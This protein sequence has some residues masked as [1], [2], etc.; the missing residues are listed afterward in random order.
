[1]QKSY[2]VY[3][4][5]RDAPRWGNVVHTRLDNFTTSIMLMEAAYPAEGKI[6]NS[7]LLN[8]SWPIRNGSAAGTLVEVSQNNFQAENAAWIYPRYWHGYLVFLKPLLTFFNLQILR[9]INFLLQ[10]F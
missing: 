10:F 9:E 8:P 4:V 3:K 2:G 7:A 6:L 1:M 5:E